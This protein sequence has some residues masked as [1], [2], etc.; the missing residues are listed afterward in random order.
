MNVL[1]FSTLYPNAASPGHGV[2]VENRVRHL[3]AGGRVN[4][5]VVAPVPWFPFQNPR[6]G[7]YAAFARAPAEEVRH[8]ISVVHPRYLVIPKIGTNVAPFLLFRGAWRTVQR[9]LASGYTFDLIDAH[10]FYP[11]GVAAVMLAQR[12]GK[13]V[14]ITARGTDLNVLPEFPLPRRIIQWAAHRADGL[15]TVC[16]ALKR[17]LVDLGVPAGRVRVLRNGVDLEMFR[18]VDRKAARDRLGLAGPTLLSVGNLIPLKGH[19]LVISALAD[20]PD[21]DLII[22]GSG[23]EEAALRTLSERLGV[24]QRVRFLGRVGHES[25]AEIYGA[26]DALVLASSRE[27]WANVLLEAMACGTPVVASD[28]SGTPEVV[29]GPEAGL[30]M[31]ERSVAGATEAIR[32]LLAAPPD[33]DATRTFAEGFSWD[34]TTAGQIA[35]FD[36]IVRG[37]SSVHPDGLA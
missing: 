4:T 25:M 19:D 7:P 23:P 33:R 9:I 16:E 21:V 11:D 32:A 8:G 26:A 10:Y 13:P 22:A 1:T 30:L 5:R 3:V 31:R 37:R 17:V 27:G 15:I 12:L 34:P 28:V 6:F 35:L 24:A 29:C 2:F 36:E 20:L 14:T 18:P